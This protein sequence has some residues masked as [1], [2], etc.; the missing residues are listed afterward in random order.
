MAEA[1]LSFILLVFFFYYTIIFL[2]KLVTIVTNLSEKEFVSKLP[3]SYFCLVHLLFF[4]YGFLVAAVYP[5][6][7]PVLWI[8]TLKKDFNKA[9]KVLKEHIRG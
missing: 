7:L 1:L 9:K 8:S 4:L 6:Y 3:Y 5:F 2:F